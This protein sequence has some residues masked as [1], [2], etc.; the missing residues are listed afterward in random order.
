MW[1]L[2]LLET[3]VIMT[4]CTLH[5]ALRYFFCKLSDCWEKHCLVCSFKV[6]VDRSTVECNKIGDCIYL[7][8][9][10]TVLRLWC[11]NSCKYE[12]GVLIS[13]CS[14]LKSWLNTHTRW[15]CWA[16]EVYNQSWAFFYQFLKLCQ[17]TNLE[18]FSE[19][20]FSW[21]RRSSWCTTHSTHAT[22]SLHE[23]VQ[24][25]WVH[26]SNHVL[27][28]WWKSS[29][30]LRHASLS[31]SRLLLLTTTIGCSSTLA[32]DS[33]G[34]S[35]PEWIFSASLFIEDW[36]TLNFKVIL[37]PRHHRGKHCS[38]WSLQEFFWLINDV[39]R[40]AVS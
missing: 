4:T 18:Y 8:G 40:D 27:D 32:I 3:H 20:W 15:A 25:L 26:T 2:E 13:F 7:E 10:S 19:F 22:K 1:W 12:V 23:L 34:R 38:K 29:W 37:H 5:F 14:T 30:H 17:V 9:T 24:L 16:P 21:W 11:V 35:V 31:S 33:S 28:I 6:F 36:I 39:C